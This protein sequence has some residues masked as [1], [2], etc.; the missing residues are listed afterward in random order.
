MVII[1]LFLDMN[2]KKNICLYWAP[3]SFGDIV[4]YLLIN[5]GYTSAFNNPYIND[6]GRVCYSFNSKFNDIFN[7]S[8]HDQ[9]YFYLRD[10]TSEDLIKMSAIENYIICTHRLE[11]A[12]FIK[13][14]LGDQIQSIGIIYTADYYEIV[15]KN[16]IDKVV[17]N[18]P[19]AEE[20]ISQYDPKLIKAFKEKNLYTQY[21]LKIFHR[22]GIKEIPN[23]INNQFDISIPINL[24]INNE[25]DS[26]INLLSLSI[27]KNSEEFF[28][29]WHQKQNFN[30]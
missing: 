9:D 29:L 13:N 6:I 23:Q 27:D 8:H 14:T 26:L 19:E 16:C 5:S 2:K 11:Q 25:L 4:N 20:K 17:A 30:N 10:W 12:E 22:Y 15:L 21:L 1:F 7:L 28:N 24:L 18:S 3:G